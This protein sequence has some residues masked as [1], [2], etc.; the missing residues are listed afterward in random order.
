MVFKH[1]L[2]QFLHLFRGNPAFSQSYALKARHF[3]PL[4]LFNDFD[5]GTCL[6]QRV[7]STGIQPCE[8]SAQCLYFQFLVL[9]KLLVYGGDFQF[10]RA[11]GLIFLATSTTL[12]G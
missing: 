9:K 10:S 12:L 3:Q 2:G 6:G 4:A 1:R 5:V 7:V 11:E 8:T